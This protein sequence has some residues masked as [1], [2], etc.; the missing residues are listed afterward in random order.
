MQNAKCKMQNRTD[1][2]KISLWLILGR[3]QIAGEDERRMQ[4]ANHPEAYF[5]T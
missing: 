2:K 5:R 1:R 4:N 3:G